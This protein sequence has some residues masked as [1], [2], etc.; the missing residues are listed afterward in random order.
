MAA[1]DNSKDR[2][3]YD[4]ETTNVTF[5]VPKS[6][7]DDFDHLILKKKVDLELDKSENRSSV[8]RNYMENC[9]R[10]GEIDRQ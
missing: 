8:L 2:Q 9:V 1:S 10:K 5:R 3:Q 6:L 7:V 4:G